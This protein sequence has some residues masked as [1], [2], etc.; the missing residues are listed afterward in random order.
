MNSSKT[1]SEK[2]EL[3]KDFKIKKSLKDKYA[4]QPL[5]KNKVERANHILKTVAL[6]KT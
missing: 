2:K 6:P 3:P 1:K 5:F 4:D